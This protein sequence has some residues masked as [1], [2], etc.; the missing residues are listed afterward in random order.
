MM[1]TLF[2]ASS[3]RT[4]PYSQQSIDESD[5]AFSQALLLEAIDKSYAMG[6]VQEK[7]QI[8]LENPHADGR[9]DLLVHLRA[10]AS[11]VGLIRVLGIV[12]GCG[13][14]AAAGPGRASAV[15]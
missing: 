8:D 10:L 4:I 7:F 3:S 15:N 1:L 13:A 12:G 9:V 5:R 14:R 2:Y 11:V 6:Y